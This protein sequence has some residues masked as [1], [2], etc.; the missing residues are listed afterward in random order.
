MISPD[1]PRATP[2]GLTSTSVRSTAA[3]TA[4]ESTRA[5]PSAIRVGWWCLFASVGGV[6]SQR[7]HGAAVTGVTVKSG[8]LTHE[9][10]GRGTPNPPQ[11]GDQHPNPARCTDELVPQVEQVEPGPEKDR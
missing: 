8:L 3:V 10:A 11:S 5:R 6:D 7:A 4:G 1:R 9:R 2:S